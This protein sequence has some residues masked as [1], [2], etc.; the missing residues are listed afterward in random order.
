MANLTANLYKDKKVENNNL[1]FILL[2]SI[3]KG[4][5]KKD[6]ALSDFQK[7]MQNFL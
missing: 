5:V 1:V 2:S 6:I 4:I 7:V 3:G